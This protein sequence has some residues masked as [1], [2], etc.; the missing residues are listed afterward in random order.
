MHDATAIHSN[1]LSAH[2]L[3]TNTKL[4]CPQP[5]PPSLRV[6]ILHPP[7]CWKCPSTSQPRTRC[8]RSPVQH[9]LPEW[10]R[11]S[12]D[13]ALP[14]SATSVATMTTTSDLA[15]IDERLRSEGSRP[16]YG[17]DL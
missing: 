4:V 14:I 3:G 13:L 8:F 11:P 17:L 2:K 15:M 1:S 9:L 5:S 12:P 10:L 7:F 16:F 6:L